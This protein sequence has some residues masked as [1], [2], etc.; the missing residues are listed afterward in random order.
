LS[1]SIIAH[2]A[3]LTGHGTLE[4]VHTRRIA[5]FILGAWVAGSLF[6]LFISIQN[7]RSA[8]ALLLSPLPEAAKIMDDAGRDRAALLLR[9]AAAEETRSALF[10]WEKVQIPLAIALGGFLFLGTQ[11][12]IFPLVL[13]GAMFA[14]V[15]FQHLGISTELA[16]LGRETDFPPGDALIGPQKRMIALEEVYYA[17]EAIKLV[18]AGILASFLFV[19]RARRARKEIVTLDPADSRAVN[20]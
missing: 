8:N 14:L 6:M 11:K 15:V 10:A 17:A 3:S 7:A 4:Q 12:R 19:F 16:Y 13:C 20:G 18:A 1:G 5:S 2:P 9:H